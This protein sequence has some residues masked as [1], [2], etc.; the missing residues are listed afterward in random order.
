MSDLRDATALAPLDA[1]G[2]FSLARAPH[3][4]GVVTLV[5][6]D[7]ARVSAFY[8]QA[9]G[10]RSI[11][12]GAGFERLGTGRATLLELRHQ[13]G[14]EPQSRRDAGLFH[15]AFLLPGRKELGQW[16]SFAAAAGLRLDGAADHLVSEAIYLAD[17]EGNGIEIYCDRKV[18]AW[19]RRDGAIQM[20]SDPLDLEGVMQA[21]AGQ[22]WSGFPEGG[23]I[24]HVH[25]QVGAIA[26]AD[27]FYNTLLG[28]DITC[29]YPGASFYGS[30]GYH[31]QL[32]GNIWNSR[33][34]APRRPNTT[35]L[36]GFELL[37]SDPAVIAATAA[38]IEAAD[39]PMQAGL[40]LP[41]MQASLHL[42]RC[43][44]ASISGPGV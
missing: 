40:H 6:K 12:T 24:G 26:A 20:A 35:G 44:L 22:S 23:T 2:R 15:T 8:Q 25:L 14:A 31:H 7:L 21:A 11:A 17:P 3:R 33:G 19:P 5:V 38:R 43:G 29:R 28:F 34:A 9:I 18:A 42:L 36:A 1:D 32:A 27:A 39:P 4:I 30:G 10:L 37:T 13:P 41:E 16:L